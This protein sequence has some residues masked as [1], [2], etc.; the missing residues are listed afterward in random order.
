M[1][2]IQE[3]VAYIGAWLAY[4]VGVFYLILVTI[5]RLWPSSDPGSFPTLFE[6]GQSVF[7]MGICIVTMVWLASMLWHILSH[8]YLRHLRPHVLRQI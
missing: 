5:I 1:T 3:K 2:K 6:W 8:L 7:L 4:N